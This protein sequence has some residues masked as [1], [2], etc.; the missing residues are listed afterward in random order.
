MKSLRILLLFDLSVKIAPEDYKLYWDTPDWKTEKDIKNTLKKLG[1]EVIPLGIY[2]DIEPIIQTVQ[3]EKPDLVFNMSEAFSGNRD[4]EPDMT[5][6]LQL[7]G[8]PFTG[9]GPLGLRLCKDKG[10]TKIILN[11]HNIR[12]P[13]FLMIKK[14]APQKSLKEFTFPAFVK[15]LQLESSEG[16][17]QSSYVENEKDALARIKFVHESLGVDAIIEEYIEG[18][19]LYVS[20]LGNEKLTVFPPRE[21]FFKEVP[22][23]EPKFATYRS[24]WDKEYRKK[25]G[26]D[27]GYVKSMPEGLQKNINETCKKIYK[28]LSIQG[29]GRIDLRVKQN[30]EIYFIEANPNPS[31]GKN[32]DYSLSASR[33]GVSYDE[34]LSKIISL[35][36]HKVPVNAQSHGQSR[37]QA[38][39][40]A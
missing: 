15:P 10:L 23:D 25:W 5:S 27:T 2:N 12:T 1:H 9:A 3:K 38:T 4:F 29:Y 17:S 16:I 30:G 39:A 37:S 22:E 35:A 19:E 31:I 6:L 26:I 14:A 34:L 11:Y 8:V 36:M 33:D 32:E 18:R 21:L 13:Q 28:L 20:V 24:K 7:M 40:A